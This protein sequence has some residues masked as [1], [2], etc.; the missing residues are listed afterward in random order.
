MRDVLVDTSIWID[1]FR[2]GEHSI[3]LNPLIEA[4]RVV[5]NDLIL[6]ELVPFLRVKGEAR[7]IRLLNG[8]PKLA[9]Q[10]DWEAI[11]DL[12][13][14]CLKSGVNEVGIPDL[15]IAQNSEQNDCAV[16]SLDKHFA[17]LQKTS[18]PSCTKRRDNSL[19]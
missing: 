11:I 8:L 12:Q 4:H 3:G 10:I 7:A 16:Y 18:G 9:L 19:V 1:Y 17:L 13:V 15:I 5:T 14:Q 2:S 6:T